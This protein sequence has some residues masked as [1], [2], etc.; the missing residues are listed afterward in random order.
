VQ[1]CWAQVK[2]VKTES[3]MKH[4]V[5]FIAMLFLFVFE[6]GAAHPVLPKQVPPPQ[7]NISA[8]FIPDWE[9]PADVAAYEEREFIQRLEGLSIALT[10][11]AATYKGGQVDLKKVKT[12]RKALHEL[13]KSEWFRPQKAK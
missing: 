4:S 9:S 3:H 11:F 13:E 7:M 2:T 5:R 6:A 10:D 8:P 1:N 12:L